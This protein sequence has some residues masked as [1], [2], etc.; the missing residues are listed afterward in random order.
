MAT[1]EMYQLSEDC[2][3]SHFIQSP[4]SSHLHLQVQFLEQNS[5]ALGASLCLSP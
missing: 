4:H 2:H 1:Q 5:V 3:C